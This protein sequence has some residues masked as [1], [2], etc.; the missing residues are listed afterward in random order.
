MGTQKDE[1]LPI[2]WERGGTK[3]EG[4]TVSP[5]RDEGSGS[6]SWASRRRRN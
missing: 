6:R 5:L 3:T 2:E 1:Q 4:K